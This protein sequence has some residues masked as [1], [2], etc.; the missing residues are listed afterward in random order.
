[1]DPEEE[2]EGLFRSSLGRSWGWLIVVVVVFVVGGGRVGNQTRE[3]C[4]WV[5]LMKPHPKIKVLASNHPPPGWQRVY[6]S[7]GGPR[8]KEKKKKKKKTEAT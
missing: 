6:L 3:S 7:R 5:D 2:G 1:M 4:D 8:R